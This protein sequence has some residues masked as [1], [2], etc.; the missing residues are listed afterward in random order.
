[1]D[2]NGKRIAFYKRAQILIADIWACFEG[3]GLGQFDDIDTVTMF[4]D[5]RIPQALLFFDALQYSDKLKEYLAKD[6]MLKSGET[7]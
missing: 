3:Q 4:A 7:V 5:Y 1:M 2:Y 6:Q